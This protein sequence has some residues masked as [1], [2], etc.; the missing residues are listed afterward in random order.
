MKIINSLLLIASLSIINNVLGIPI[1]KNYR[2]NENNNKNVNNINNENS[3]KKSDD[4]KKN[5]IQSF[6]NDN[7][8][9]IAMSL[10]NS[11]YQSSLINKKPK[12]IVISTKNTN[13]FNKKEKRYIKYNGYGSNT[14]NYVEYNNYINRQNNNNNNL[15][16]SKENTNASSISTTIF[17]FN[18]QETTTTTKPTITTSKEIYDEIPT[19]VISFDIS[20]S[21]TKIPL[22]T[23][24]KSITSKANITSKTTTTTKTTKINKT[25]TTKTTKKTTT[26]KP[27]KTVMKNNPLFSSYIFDETISRCLT[28]NDCGKLNLKDIKMEPHRV[29]E[30][31]KPNEN[32]YSKKISVKVTCP[33]NQPNCKAPIPTILPCLHGN[34]KLK[35]EKDEEIEKYIGV[36]ELD[37]DENEIVIDMDS[38]NN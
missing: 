13:I 14:N 22:T 34:C 12:T 35:K 8:Q 17:K 6:D 2:Y 4:L 15:T 36:K 26:Y 1:N 7:E 9:F 21:T 5:H 16:K 10:N 29:K 27:N 11:K 32:I 3:S 31:F 18:I 30:P 25:T 23:S 20:P 33:E 28:H 24:K 19:A 38:D 37:E